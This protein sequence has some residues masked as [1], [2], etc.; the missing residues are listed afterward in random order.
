MLVKAKKIYEFIKGWYR[1]NEM[2]GWHSALE[3]KKA[4]ESKTENVSDINLSLIAALKYADIPVALML[5]S[6]RRNGMPTE[7]YPVLSEFNY[8][9]AKVSIPDK[10]CLLDATDPYLSFGLIPIR[11][12][13]GKG[14]VFGEK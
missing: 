10:I 2:Y 4:F 5:L 6:T 12:L 7:L 8:V 1:W 11:C 9:I 14:R 13:N 3:I